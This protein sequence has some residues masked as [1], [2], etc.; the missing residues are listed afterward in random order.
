[1]ML[2]RNI[3]PGMYYPGRSV[4]HRLQVRTKLIVMIWLVVVVFL[5]RQRYWSVTPFLVVGGF[6]GL[7]CLFSGIG[8][9]E[10]WQRL[11]LI[12]GLTLLS[13]LISLLFFAVP[14]E[15]EKIIATFGPLP[16]AY[17]L[18]RQIA[19]VVAIVAAFLL[20]CRVIPPLR[21]IWE[22]VRKF[23]MFLFL[24]VS[25]SL[26][27]LL[28]TWRTPAAHI[29]SIGPWLLPYQMSWWVV[30]GVATFLIFYVLAL[31]ITLT[32]LPVVLIEGLTMLLAPLRVLRLPVDDFA[33]MA[34]LALRFFPTL[35]DEADQLLKAQMARGADFTHGS[36]RER[37][38]SLRTFF[39]LL[40]QGALRR[41][42]ELATA[43]E[44]RG[45]QIEG[46][47]TRLHE[48]ALG[49]L[50]YS[51]LVVVGLGTLATLLFA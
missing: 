18:V 33:L 39:V 45:Y 22:H 32:T 42:S 31:L 14:D 1:M 19:S 36:L 21:G 41:A 24:L 2:L 7:G 29:L 35:F 9:R 16:L 3:V 27:F 46:R 13:A 43:L 23:R 50:D 30:V 26:I 5:A 10:F 34:L 49:W 28:V 48:T 25:A 40:V 15:G 4:L 6:V 37:I 38:L 17:G 44:A 51:V 11:R 8:I 20:F 12:V 47:Q